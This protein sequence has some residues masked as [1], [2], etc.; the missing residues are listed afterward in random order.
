MIQPKTGREE[1]SGASSSESSHHQVVW[2]YNF[3]LALE[4][5]HLF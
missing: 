5:D 2:W 1:M 4:N 3:M